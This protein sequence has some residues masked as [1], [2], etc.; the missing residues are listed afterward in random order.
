MLFYLLKKFKINKLI[1]N[2]IK[3]LPDALLKY[4]FNYS[5]ELSKRDMLDLKEKVIDVLKNDNFLN[6]LT[7][8][9]EKYLVNKIL[10]NK[11]IQDIRIYDVNEWLP[12][13]QLFKMDKIFMRY[14][15]ENRDPYLSKDL[16]SNALNAPILSNFSIF[17]D[18]LNFRNAILKTNFPSSYLQKRKNAFTRKIGTSNQLFLEEIKEKI[19][20]YR[21][22]LENFLDS[23]FLDSLLD[24]KK[25]EYSMYKEKQLFTIGSFLAWY[26]NIK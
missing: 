12:N 8:I 7:V 14:S 26:E 10:Y 19:I 25:N 6:L 4:I 9:D 13:S 17:S 24:T 18:K 1:R 21:K 15:I 16:V 5:L 20:E 2:G 11:S 22:F 3:F 23:L